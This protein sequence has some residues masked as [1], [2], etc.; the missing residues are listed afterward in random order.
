MNPYKNEGY[1][2]VDLS[3][4][5]ISEQHRVHRLIAIAFIANPLKLPVVDHIDNNRKNNNVTNLRWVTQAQNIQY[6][7]DNHKTKKTKKILQYNLDGELIKKWKSVTILCKKYPEYNSSH[8]YRNINGKSISAYGYKWKY[9]NGE[10]NIK[11]IKKIIPDKNFKIIREYKKYDLSNYQVSIFGV[12]INKKNE[13]MSQ[14]ITDNGYKRI[15]IVCNKSKK[16]NTMYVHDLVAHCFI[17]NDNPEINDV[18]NH[19]DKNRSNNYYKNLEWVTQ[20][21]NSIHSN[22]KMVKMINPTDNEVLKIFR[23]VKDA[24][25]FL[26]VSTNSHIGEVCNGKWKTY[27]GYKWEWVKQNEIIDVPIITVPLKKY[28]KNRTKIKILNSDEFEAD[29]DDYDVADYEDIKITKK[30]KKMKK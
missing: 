27:K 17:K 25:R 8:I 16:D 3:A 19:I 11:K 26:N 13:V 1:F 29:D 7:I 10:I 6:Y 12:V 15:H 14:K 22:G 28:T 23:C 4:G 21:D 18:V 9:A 2:C 5:E 24:D 30:V 20:Q